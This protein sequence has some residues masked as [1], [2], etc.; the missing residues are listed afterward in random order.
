MN[1]LEIYDKIDKPLEAVEK[2]G[3]TFAQSGMF[4]IEYAPEW[5]G[6]W[7]ESLVEVLNNA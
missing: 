2:M 1:E 7:K 6:D 5:D 4:G 3:K